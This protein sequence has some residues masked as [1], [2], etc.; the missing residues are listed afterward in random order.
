MWKKSTEFLVQFYTSFPY[1]QIA[2]YSETSWCRDTSFLM[3]AELTE[4]S[5]A[6]WNFATWKEEHKST[7]DQTQLEGNQQCHGGQVYY[8]C[9]ARSK[10]R[11]SNNCNNAHQNGSAKNVEHCENLGGTW[12]GTASYKSTDR[13]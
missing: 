12:V 5:S 8:L 1:A 13:K 9:S 4:T 10:N 2:I 11:G 6:S 7:A 3:V